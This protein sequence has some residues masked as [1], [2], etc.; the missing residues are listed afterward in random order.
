MKTIIGIF[1]GKQATNNK[2]LLKT[3]YD[4]CP[5]T[6]WELTKKSG[7]PKKPYSLY[8]IYFKRLKGLEKKGYV[9][10][11][12]RKWVLQFKGIIAVLIIQSQPKPWS[13]KW[14]KIFEDYAKP[15]KETSK[16]FAIV[17]DGKEI[18]DLSDIAKRVPINLRKFESWVALANEIK[19]LMEKG[20]IN[21]DVITNE[22][23][24]LLILTEFSHGSLSTA[25]GE[26][27]HGA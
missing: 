15:L 18:A 9:K 12:G 17:E 26:L 1:Q 5:L 25:L 8:A 23:L 19:K 11:V 6:A 3:L 20:F 7:E 22:S 10:H 2:F 27:G 13:E 21:L 4:N 24:L 16:K 14:T